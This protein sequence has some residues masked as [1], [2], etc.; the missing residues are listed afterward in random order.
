MAMVVPNSLQVATI[1]CLMSS[2][3]L[4]LSL[5]KW[6]KK[7][8]RLLAVHLLV[9]IVTLFYMGIGMN[10]GAPLE[11]M[12]QIL[13]I[14]VVSPLLWIIIFAAMV[15]IASAEALERVFV[16]VSLLAA[17]SVAL[18]YFLYFSFGSSSVSFFREGANLNYKD[19]YAGA[20][21]HVYGALIFF[22]SGLFASPGII[23]S[24]VLRAVLLGGL[25]LAAITSGRSALIMS[26][27]LGAALGIVFQ[28]R[29]AGGSDGRRRSFIRMSKGVLFVAFGVLSVAFLLP[30]FTDVD[31][32]LI[33]GMFWDELSSGGGSAR[34]E[35]ARALLEGVGEHYG[36][37]AG[38]GVGVDYIRSYTFP[39]RYEMVWV[40]TLFRVGLIG[41]LVYSVAFVMCFAAFCR[42][43]I[44]RSLS[45][46]DL[47]LGV[48]FVS[49]VLASNTNP[50]IEAFTLQWMFALPIVWFLVRP[51]CAQSSARSVAHLREEQID[52]LIIDEHGRFR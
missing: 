38:H 47:F 46:L 25:A 17:A 20:T 4:G 40:A 12:W 10:S 8:F 37:G 33:V 35:Q 24:N 39:W 31:I 34:S 1:A 42:L 7:L 3:V 15:Q 50:Y 29:L 44:N 43:A 32:S 30:V 41:A 23:R 28:G 21:M 16:S 19:G 22:T 27:P 6:T 36:L 18:F 13:V 26:I 45:E 9:S 14:Y 52:S 11:A 49:A 2:F 5:V 48:G 51:A